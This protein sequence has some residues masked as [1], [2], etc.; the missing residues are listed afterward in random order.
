MD[1]K[2]KTKNRILSV[3]CGHSGPISSGKITELLHSAGVMVSERTVR[4]HL[5]EADAEGLTENHPRKGRTITPRGLEEIRVSQ[6]VQRVGYLSA[7]IDQMTYRMSF[8][9]QRRS[10]TVVVNTS[11]VDIP[12]LYRYSRDICEVFRRGYAM[13]TRMCL[14]TEGE[15][16][17]D[18]IIPPGKVGFCTVCTITING[19]LLKH[20]IPATSRFGGLLELRNGE[21]TRFVEVI[22]YDGTSIDPLEVF[23]RSGMTNYHGAISDGNGRVGASFRELPAG[24]REAVVHLGEELDAIGLGAIADIGL[25]DQAIHGVPVAPGRI[26]MILIGGLNPIAILEERNHRVDSMAL[27]G[28][29]EFN[30]LHSYEELPKRLKRLL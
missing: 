11:I 2:Q 19:V 14:L 15:R 28:L 27:S 21:P 22:H 4:L 16:I 26:G 24:C 17:G 6:A 18:T 25:A 8:D 3:L 13:G 5:V 29:L 23:I 30:R 7:K 12:L 9:L 20:G 10:G 1:R